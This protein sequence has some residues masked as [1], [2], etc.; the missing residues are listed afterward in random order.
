MSK[1]NNNNG[2]LEED[3][4]EKPEEEEIE[5]ED[6]VNDEEDEAEVINPYK[7]VDPHNR[8]PSTSNEE[9]EFAPPV[10]QIADADDVPIPP[11][12]QGVMKLSKQMHNRENRSKNSKMM[13]LITGLS[14]EFTVLKNQNHKAEELSHWEAW[15]RGRIPNNLRFQ[16]EPSIYTAPLPRTDDPYVM[17]RDA[18]MD[19]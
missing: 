1:L 11:V 5:D 17:V 10:V 12:I 3:P 6:M 2:W 19:T 14:R 18:A 15:V 7:E 8:P 16:E 4:K 13:K 9:T